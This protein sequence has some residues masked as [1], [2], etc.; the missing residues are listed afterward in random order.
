MSDDRIDK[1]FGIAPHLAQ[2]QTIVPPLF[3]FNGSPY[4]FITCHVT[5]L[6]EPLKGSNNVD[7]YLALSANPGRIATSSLV[8]AASGR[9]IKKN[10]I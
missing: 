6:N 9:R 10:Q 3:L 1:K 8:A 4:I 5:L 2:V 7:F